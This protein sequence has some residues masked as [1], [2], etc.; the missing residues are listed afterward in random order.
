MQRTMGSFRRPKLLSRSIVI[1]II[2]SPWLCKWNLEFVIDSVF[3]HAKIWIIHDTISTYFAPLN[4]FYVGLKSFTHYVITDGYWLMVSR[5]VI[6]HVSVIYVWRY[7][8]RWTFII[9][10]HRNKWRK[11]KYTTNTPSTTTKYMILFT[12]SQYA[13]ATMSI[14]T[15]T[16]DSSGCH[17]ALPPLSG[18]RLNKT[19]SS[20]NMRNSLA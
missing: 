16:T 12:N 4:T 18:I 1:F 9:R 8:T 10:R 20:R 2:T 5:K 7:T 6:Y 17:V 15:D 13:H 3:V 11:S 14:P 19:R